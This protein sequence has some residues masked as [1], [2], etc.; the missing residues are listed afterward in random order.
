MALRR[1]LCGGTPHLERRR[2]MK[3]RNGSTKW[4]ALA[5]VGVGMI[6]ATATAAGALHE[7]HRGMWKQHVS[8]RIDEALDA[9]AATPA[10]RSAIRVAR[11]RM[12]VA[13]EATHQDHQRGQA[14]PGLR[15]GAQRR[16]GLLQALALF[17]ADQ[18]DG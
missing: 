3:P 12:F 5:A 13:L 2:S 16:A 9:A 10:Q 6:G 8:A 14:P 18:L 17:E 7:H 1:R 11:D 15:P 4:L